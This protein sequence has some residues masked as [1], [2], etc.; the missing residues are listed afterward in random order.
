MLLVAKDEMLK[1]NYGLQFAEN[2]AE[3]REMLEGIN[4]VL[5]WFCLNHP[6]ARF[7]R[8]LVLS[9]FT[10]SGLE[11]DSGIVAEANSR[12]SAMLKLGEYGMLG[13]FRPRGN[14]TAK[15]FG[16]DCSNTFLLMQT[17]EE[18]LAEVQARPEL[19]NSHSC[20]LSGGCWKKMRFVDFFFKNFGKK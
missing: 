17:Y 9:G 6:T 14:E 4:D 2:E 7:C 18:S 11:H 19:T 3:A 8:T 13:E 15:R 10:L 20:I 12:F 16:T 1:S 5:T